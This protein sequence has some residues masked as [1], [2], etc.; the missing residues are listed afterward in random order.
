MKYTEKFLLIMFFLMLYSILL[1]MNTKFPLYGEDFALSIPLDAKELSI[2]Q[3]IPMIVSK[4]IQQSTK[5]NARLGEQLAIIMSSLDNVFFDILNTLVTILCFYVVLSLVKGEFIG[6]NTKNIFLFACCLLIFLI[7]PKSGDIMFWTTVS[8]NYLWGQTFIL[9]YLLPFRFLLANKEKNTRFWKNSILRVIFLIFSFL[10]GMTSENSI[11]FVILFSFTSL[12]IVRYI[13]K[14]SLGSLR[15]YWTSIIFLIAGYFYL[16]LSPS[17]FIRNEYYRSAFGIYDPNLLY[18]ISRIKTTFTIFFSSS[19]PILFILGILYALW[20][21]LNRY[22]KLGYSNENL[23]IMTLLTASSLISVFLVIFAPYTETRSFLLF[24]LLS[25]GLIS[26]LVETITSEWIPA[27]I[28]F[29]GILFFIIILFVQISTI[30]N[31]VNEISID[32]SKRHNDI[33]NQIDDNRKL[34]QVN[35]IQVNPIRLTNKCSYYFS[36]REEWLIQFSHDELYYGV[37]SIMIKNRGEQ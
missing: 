31:C 30:Y 10:V 35:P 4:I 19:Y 25:I 33:I 15:F 12:V 11:P 6:V 21:Y 3:K 5:W 24:W 8:T 27:R 14:L 37:E 2:I 9:I 22:N 13:R 23:R 29:V 1:I 36:D 7:L 16:I 34:I 17:T 26:Q 18:Y 32:L 20:L 28:L